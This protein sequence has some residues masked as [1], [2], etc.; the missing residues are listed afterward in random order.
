MG[1]IVPTRRYCERYRFRCFQWAGKPRGDLHD[2][3]LKTR[4][5][6]WIPLTPHCLRCD[7]GKYQEVSMYRIDCLTPFDHQIHNTL[8]QMLKESKIAPGQL[9]KRGSAS[10][11]L[12]GGVYGKIYDFH[13][14]Q[15]RNYLIQKPDRCKE[16]QD[17]ILA[18]CQ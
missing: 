2:A 1:R 9:L 15:L 17:A 18:V 7:C 6:K 3:L 14:R 10:V 11:S 8:D 5:W 4:R 16:M 12:A 13:L